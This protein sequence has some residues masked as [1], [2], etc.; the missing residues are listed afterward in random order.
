MRLHSSFSIHQ[1]ASRRVVQV[2]GCIL[3]IL[4]FLP[5]FSAACVLIPEP[6]VG[7]I[8]LLT[9]SKVIDICKVI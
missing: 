6:V 1:V 3:L 4:S 9:F 8:L 7:G 5:K 2:C